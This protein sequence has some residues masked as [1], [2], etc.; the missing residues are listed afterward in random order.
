MTVFRDVDDAFEWDPNF[1]YDND[2]DG[3]PNKMEDRLELIRITQ[4]LMEMEY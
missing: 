1:Q 2:D 3:F 4:I